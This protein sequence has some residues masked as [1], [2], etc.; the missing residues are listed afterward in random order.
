[1]VQLSPKQVDIVTAMFQSSDIEQDFEC[2][3]EDISERTHTN[4][5]RDQPRTRQKTSIESSA[6]WGL[7]SCRWPVLTVCL[8]STPCQHCLLVLCPPLWPPGRSCPGKHIHNRTTLWPWDR[9][10]LLYDLYVLRCLPF[11]PFP[12]SGN[13]CNGILHTA[14][15]VF[16]EYNIL[17]QYA[18][19]S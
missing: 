11:L 10:S 4:T 14:H 18:Q 6:C 5:Q 12:L 3:V 2:W 17:I 9:H 15:A 8:L 16:A 19:I 13:V 1:M 7:L